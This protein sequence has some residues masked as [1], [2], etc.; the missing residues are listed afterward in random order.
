MHG[1]IVLDPMEWLIVRSYYTALLP[2]LNFEG[3]YL[4]AELA[5]SFCNYDGDLKEFKWDIV[6]IVMPPIE[7]KPS[8]DG[9]LIAVE[10]YSVKLLHDW[11][12][13]P[14][15]VITD[16]DFNPEEV[17]NCDCLVL[18]HAHGDNINY[19]PKYASRVRKL[20]P[21]VQVWPRGCSLLIPGFTDGDRAIY[22][23]YYMGAREI[24]IYGFNPSKVVKRNDEIKRAKLEIAK[25]LINRVLQKAKG[26]TVIKLL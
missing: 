1:G 26:N 3:D 25:A 9:L 17:I 21:T 10:G 5:P 24:R 6:N 14:G 22:L 4:A 12:L 2:Q 11:G 15:I 19:Y 18:G 13:S 8:D 7:I 23:A 16:F 20:L